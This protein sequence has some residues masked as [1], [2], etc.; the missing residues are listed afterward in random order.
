[1]DAKAFRHEF[2]PNG[3]GTWTG[4]NIYRIE[5]ET[6]FAKLQEVSKQDADYYNK[7]SENGVQA[8]LVC[9]YPETWAVAVSGTV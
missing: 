2:R 3:D 8:I 7:F 6:Q 5:Q 9:G 4:W 1:M